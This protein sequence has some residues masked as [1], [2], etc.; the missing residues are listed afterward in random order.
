[1][2]VV[3][4]VVEVRAARDDDGGGG[5]D[6]GGGG[7]D[8]DEYRGRVVASTRCYGVPDPA[9][10]AD[11]F[12]ELAGY[13]PP[14]PPVDDLVDRVDVICDDGELFPVRRALLRPCLRL[15]G[16]AQG[17]RGKHAL[18]RSVGVGMDC[19]TFDRVLLYLQHEARGERFKF[20]PTLAPELL[21]AART[22][23][24][25]GLEDACAKVLG[26]FAERVSRTPFRLADIA[27]RN[28]RGGGKSP[29]A[30]TWLLLDGMVLDV[31]RWLPEH[32]G[33]DAIIPDQALDCDC[34]CMFEIYHVS[35]QSFAYLREFYAGELQVAADPITT[36]ALTKWEHLPTSG[37]PLIFLGVQ[38]KDER[39]ESVHDSSMHWWLADFLRQRFK[40][41]VDRPLS[42]WLYFTTSWLDWGIN[43]VT[44]IIRLIYVALELFPLPPAVLR[45][46][47]L[48]R[49]GEVVGVWRIC[50]V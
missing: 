8:D 10:P 37:V 16:A 26:S 30:E 13:A 18:E 34:T 24:I 12:L 1:M 7:D 39:E 38:G 11:V 9:A 27:R 4:R 15:T 2:D 17:G 3:V 23:G 40:G 41:H 43:I 45:L 14:P 5:G 44:I 28:A 31:S 46:F 6:E 35:R 29:R 21:V 20:D 48:M 19:C 47:L 22:L 33:G 49:P 25:S 42:L 32:P 50:V 36:H